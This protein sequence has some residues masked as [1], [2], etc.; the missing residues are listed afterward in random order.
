M[1]SDKL[2][3][4][5]EFLDRVHKE[6]Y[7]KPR[8]TVLE[9][10]AEIKAV[11]DLFIVGK[12]KFEIAERLGLNASYIQRC[13]DIL[14]TRWERE[15]ISDIHRFKMK[16]LDKISKMESE[17]WESWF[18]SK[19]RSKT[20]KKRTK[21]REPRKDSQGMVMTDRSGNT[22][23]HEGETDSESVTLNQGSMEYMKGIMWCVAERCRIIGLYAPKKF[24]E[25]DVT[26][27][28][29]KETFTRE[30]IL[31]KLIPEIPNLSLQQEKPIEFIDAEPIPDEPKQLEAPKLEAQEVSEE[32]LPWNVIPSSI[33]TPS[34]HNNISFEHPSS[35]KAIDFMTGHLKSKYRR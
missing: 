9:K 4:V 5:K 35:D 25:T 28:K 33:E 12:N 29:D 16:E 13:I 21:S 31:A 26:G 3:E 32:M 11:K 10:E 20:T 22:L 8:K 15:S 23:Y 30:E 14:I 18:Q 1:S 17:L 19:K 2:V 6:R 7:N 27:E 34:I 24:T